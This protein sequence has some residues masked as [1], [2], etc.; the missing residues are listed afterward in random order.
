[1]RQLQNDM[2]ACGEAGLPASIT[3]GGKCY[4]LDTTFKHDFFA[5]TGRFCCPDTGQRVVL[6]M[7]RVRSFLG[8]PLSWL[9]H[10]LRN[11]ELKFLQLLG[12]IDNVPTASGAFGRNGLIYKYI[13]GKSL[14]E[15]PD[16]P[17]HFFSELEK[18]MALLHS[19]NICYMDLNKRGNI[20]VGTDKRPYLI[21]F[22]IS[23]L[24]RAPW[25]SFFRKAFQ[26]EDL[27]HLFKHKRKF[28]PDLM[29]RQELLQSRRISWL[30]RIHRFVTYPF[31]QSRRWLLRKLYS[32]K[33]LEFKLGGLRTPENNPARFL[34]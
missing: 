21:D 4:R 8:I 6:K 31:R 9:G 3:L 2:F 17:D 15:R 29:S 22:Q 30:I 24:L 1:M 19:R 11:R 26:K 20:L 28:R 10:F 7:N 25:L 5:C 33:M 14:D 18:L 16:I 32:S 23:V 27:Y 13:E 34:K 12:D